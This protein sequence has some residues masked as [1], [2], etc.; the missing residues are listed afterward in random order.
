[1]TGRTKS[2]L[3]L[4][5]AVVMLSLLMALAAYLLHE[6]MYQGRT[7]DTA[8]ISAIPSYPLIILDAG[9]GGEDGGTSAKSGLLEKDVN[10]DITLKLSQLLI[11]GGFEVLLTRDD[12]RLLYTDKSQGKLKTQDLRSRYEIAKAHPDSLFVSIHS[13]SFPDESCGGLQ[14]YY[15]PNDMR[16]REIAGLIQ[17]AAAEYLQPENDRVIKKAD[18][19]IY[20]LD[21]IMTPAVLVE[22][23]FLSNINEAELL[24]DSGYREKLAAVIYKALCDYIA[25][26]TD[27]ASED[28]SA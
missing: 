26:S 19:K 22:C 15:S 23:G 13:N 28:I 24:A 10:L 6:L 21:R 16:S 7:D 17:T 18:S 11:L 3:R 12:D 8:P 14:V 27:N 2:A 25:E 9:H 1:M 20:L 4:T 5:A